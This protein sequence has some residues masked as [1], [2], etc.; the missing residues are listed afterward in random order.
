RYTPV[1][2]Y[3]DSKALG[4]QLLT[5]A[6]RRGALQV[7]VYRPPSVHDG[8]RD[9]TRSFAEFCRRWPLLVVGD[10]QQPVPVSLAGNV[11]A[12]VAAL[13]DA[14]DPPLIV[15]HPYEGHTV[16][17]LYET[18]G[19]GRPIRALPE[20]SVRRTLRCAEPVTRAYP[21]SAAI[22]RR[23]ELLLLGQAQVASWLS[24]TGFRPPLG[25]A[26]W[27]EVALTAARSRRTG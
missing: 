25:R 15:I 3:A 17:S 2:P 4:E 20:G 11:G 10:G 6:A 1:T 18:F 21:H 12:A 23:A 14:D 24:S 16:R 7:T 5:H 13:C 22:I 9:L 19:R 26:A 27:R 8:D